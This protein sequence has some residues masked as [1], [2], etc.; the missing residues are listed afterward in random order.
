MIKD[1]MKYFRAQLESGKE[2]VK[3]GA[4]T[5][6]EARKIADELALGLSGRV[7]QFYEVFQI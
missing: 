5:R 2:P 7:I 1:Q 6:E 3:I 4:E